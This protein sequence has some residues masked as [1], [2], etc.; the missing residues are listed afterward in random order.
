MHRVVEVVGA[1][2]RRFPER[3]EG[4]SHRPEVVD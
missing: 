3:Y 2:D 4:E 1:L